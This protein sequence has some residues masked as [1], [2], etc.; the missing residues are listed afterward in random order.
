MDKFKLFLNE[1]KIKIK[2]SDISRV[3]SY[4]IGSREQE[5]FVTGLD[6]RLPDLSRK[7]KIVYDYISQIER[8]YGSKVICSILVKYDEAGMF[9]SS[10]LEY[11]KRM[12]NCRYYLGMLY[13]LGYLG[14]KD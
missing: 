11:K 4:F 2:D 8:M 13:R 9:G 6:G 5:Y 1:E 14:K 7:E 3:Y 12:S 10:E